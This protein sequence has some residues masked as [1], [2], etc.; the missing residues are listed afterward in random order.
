MK[1]SEKG[2]KGG[3]MEAEFI[4]VESSL[5]VK[6][7]KVEHGEA[8]DLVKEYGRDILEPKLIKRLEIDWDNKTM[9]YNRMN[10]EEI[11]VMFNCDIK[12]SVTHWRIS[13]I[14]DGISICSKQLR[15]CDGVS[16][17]DV[18]KKIYSV[19]SEGRGEEETWKVLLPDLENPGHEVEKMASLSDF[20]H[21]VDLIKTNR[22]IGIS[23]KDL[24]TLAA[25]Y[26]SGKEIKTSV[27]GPDGELIKEVDLLDEQINPRDDYG[28]IDVKG[29]LEHIGSIEVQEGLQ[30]LTSWRY[31]SDGHREMAGHALQV[32]ISSDPTD[33]L[34]IPLSGRMAADITLGDLLKQDKSGMNG[35]PQEVAEIDEEKT[36]AF[37]RFNVT[38]LQQRRRGGGYRDVSK[39]TRMKKA[40]CGLVLTEDAYSQIEKSVDESDKNNK[41]SKI[42]L[43][44]KNLDGQII[45]GMK[46][47]YD[48][49][50]V[51]TRGEKLSAKEASDLV[52]TDVIIPCVLNN[53][54]D[55][56]SALADTYAVGGNN[57]SQSLIRNR[58]KFMGF[59]VHITC[60]NMEKD[61][62]PLEDMCFKGYD[63][64]EDYICRRIQAGHIDQ[65]NAEGFAQHMK[66]A[67]K[68]A[69]GESDNEYVKNNLDDAKNDGEKMFQI[70]ESIFGEEADEYVDKY[71]KEGPTAEFNKLP[72]REEPAQYKKGKKKFPRE[73]A[74]Y[75]FDD[76]VIKLL[77]EKLTKENGSLIEAI[78][79]FFDI[80]FGDIDESLDA[81]K[82]IN[83]FSRTVELLS[84]SDRKK[85]KRGKK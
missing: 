48:R 55:W 18:P 15:I 81:V 63:Q 85:I 64:L 30:L 42:Y 69:A 12:N 9:D 4:G 5:E 51:R 3:E 6:Q 7:K 35:Q 16:G 56:L 36:G 14:L 22:D 72:G 50:L 71:I 40:M 67:S 17:S 47:R 74:K 83:S 65:P 73:E 62:Y 37:I 82:L 60:R 66:D 80:E 33:M 49:A 77:R 1:S 24:K 59:E 39:T 13:K 41:V 29:Y 10:F 2:H 58:E 43:C 76:I 25:E 75:S 19:L 84:E 45:H 23:K 8:C 20:A 31:E 27:H 44:G 38:D 70:F 53:P 68:Q 21:F 32:N 79:R 78:N 26:F 11:Y 52:M 57:G 54:N 61:G 28:K 46:A 34:F